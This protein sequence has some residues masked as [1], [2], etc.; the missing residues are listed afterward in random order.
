MTLFPYTTLFRSQKVLTETSKAQL[1]QMLPLFHWSTVWTIGDGEGI[2]FWFDAW[3]NSPI[4]VKKFPRPN[5]L[6]ITL[7]SAGP[8][9]QS[10]YPAKAPIMQLMRFIDKRDELRWRWEVSGSYTAKSFYLPI[11]SGGKIR[12]ANY[13]LWKYKVPETVRIFSF[14]L[15]RAK[16]LDRK[17]T[18]LNSSHAQ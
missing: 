11:L 6:T 7:R 8:I 3:D 13:K 5:Q 12:D 1:R 10:L 2:S 4:L 15:F 18:R 9:I 17:S 14:L 16:I